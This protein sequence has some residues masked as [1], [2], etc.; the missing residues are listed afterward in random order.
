MDELII[1]SL[2][3]LASPEEELALRAWRD[4]SPE[5]EARYRALRLVWSATE[6]LLPPARR[7]RPS[8]ASVVHAASEPVSPGH[9]STVRSWKPW[10]TRATVAG[11]L[12][13]SFVVGLFAAG[14][15]E[16]SSGLDS[17]ELRTGSGAGAAAPGRRRP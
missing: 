6:K 9:A 5:N 2:Q 17:G 12:A 10:G 11:L 4:E 7:P 13:A 14:G 16:G 15:F 3:E 1:T 8:A